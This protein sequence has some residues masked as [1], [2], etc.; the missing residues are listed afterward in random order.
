M[1]RECGIE[2]ERGMEREHGIEREHEME[3]EHGME[4]ERVDPLPLSCIKSY[5]YTLRCPSLFEY[6]VRHQ[7]IRREITHH[8][9]V[10]TFFVIAFA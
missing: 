1:E 2:H 10:T 3:R 6:F 5:Q 4:R 9:S 7:H 8:L